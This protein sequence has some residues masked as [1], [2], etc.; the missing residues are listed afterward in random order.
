M[1]NDH[2]GCGEKAPSPDGVALMNGQYGC[3]QVQLAGT[4]EALY[5]RRNSR[6]FLRFRIPSPAQFNHVITLVS[7]G[8]E[9]VWL[10]TTTE[11]ATLLSTNSGSVP[12]ESD[13][14][15]ASLP[16]AIR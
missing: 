8:K 13:S 2:Q 5:E 14:G 15:N 6:S 16:T 9:E 4:D 3:G 7:V 1:T 11:V 10:D 12:P